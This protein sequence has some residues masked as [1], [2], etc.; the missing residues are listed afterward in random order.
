MNLEKNHLSLSERR[1]PEWTDW[2]GRFARS[3][4]PQPPSSS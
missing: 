1:G 4:V 2:T 3:C